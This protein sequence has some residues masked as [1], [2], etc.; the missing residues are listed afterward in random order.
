LGLAGACEAQAKDADLAAAIGRLDALLRAPVRKTEDAARDFV[1]QTVAVDRLVETTFGKYLEDSLDDYD[2][3]L[4]QKRFRRLVAHYN[5]RLV[6][7]YRER[8]V[9]DL[10]DRLA[11]PALRGLRLEHLELDGKRGQVELR[12]LFPDGSVDLRADLVLG[13]GTWK[14][15]DLDIDGVP[16]SARY[17]RLYKK[18]IDKGYSLPVLESRLAKRDFI[19]LDDFSATWDGTTPMDWGAW[20]KKDKKKPLLYRIEGNGDRR[21]MAAQDSG[22]SVILGKFI[23]WNPREYPIMTWCWR[24]DA[25]PPGGNEFLNHANDS[26]AGLYVTFSQNWLGVPKQL[27]YVWSTTLPE[28]TVGRRKKIFRP[29]FYVLE[30]GEANLGKWTFETVDLEKHH[31]DKLG[32]R[33]ADRTLALGLLTDANSTSSYAEAYYADLRV[34]KRKALQSG[35]ITNYCGGLQQGAP[36]SML[37][38]GPSRGGAYSAEE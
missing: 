25:L 36:R 38:A 18:L 34:W 21:Y 16:I 1:R 28:G 23:H 19:V 24:A 35:R 11:I 37:E 2:D 6:T 30:S 7:A 3:I 27:K 4:P 17:R 9:A 8:L 26:A 29:W 20:R 14:I 12:A 33:P 22:Y 13:G 5:E 32:G 10:A 31:R 15:A